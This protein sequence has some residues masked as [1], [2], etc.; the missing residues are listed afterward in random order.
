[1]IKPIGTCPKCGGKVN[2][3]YRDEDF[4]GD[5]MLLKFVGWK[6]SN[7]CLGSHIYLY[8]SGDIPRAVKLLEEQFASVCQVY[9]D[10]KDGKKKVLPCESSEE[11]GMPVL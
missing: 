7:G 11:L 4:D 5:H 9:E 10:N 2:I 6:C 8:D 3:I 1:M